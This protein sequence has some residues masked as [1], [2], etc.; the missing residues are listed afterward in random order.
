MITTFA[1]LLG[2]AAAAPAAIGID[3]AM[4]MSVAR[5][6]VGARRRNPDSGRDG[7]RRT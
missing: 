6:S 7:G 2:V 3:V 1:E 4:T 5:T